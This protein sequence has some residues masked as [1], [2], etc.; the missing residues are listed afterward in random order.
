[1]IVVAIIGIL[2]SIALPA[3]QDFTVRA[4]VTEGLSLANNAKITVS[5]N[6]VNGSDLDVGYNAPNATANVANAGASGVAIDQTNGEVTITY[7][8]AAGDGTMVLAPHSG[9]TAIANGTIPA[10]G[11][12]N[13]DCLAFGATPTVAGASVGTLQARYAPASC[14]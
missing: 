7:T 14:R 1:M 8:P 6:A 13:W 3:Y 2:A 10:G 12:I 4:K 9:G 11:E 5:E